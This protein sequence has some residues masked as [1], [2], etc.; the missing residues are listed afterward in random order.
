MFSTEAVLSHLGSSESRFPRRFEPDCAPEGS[1][2]GL[3]QAEAAQGGL[4][5]G[6]Q[7]LPIGMRQQGEAEAASAD[8]S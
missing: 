6:V 8:V 7:R 4:R 3:F 1:I 2:G 5:A